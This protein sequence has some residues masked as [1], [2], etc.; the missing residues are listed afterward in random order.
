MQPNN[1]NAKYWPSERQETEVDMMA[2]LGYDVRLCL[3]NKKST[4]QLE[5]TGMGR[6]LSGDQIAKKA[7]YVSTDEP[8]SPA[9]CRGEE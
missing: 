1:Q 7:N 3:T 6:A 8:H 9:L 4:N 5:D 2:S